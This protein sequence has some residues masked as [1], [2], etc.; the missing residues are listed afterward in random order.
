MKLGLAW[1]GAVLLLVSVMFLCARLNAQTTSATV[2]GQITDQSGKLVSGAVVVLTNINT[3][4][5]Y[6]TVTNGEGI[7]S[8]PTLQPGVYRAN[9]T[10]DGFKSIVKPDIE[11]HVQDQVSLNFA[12]EIGSVSET[13]TVEAGGLNINTTDASV[14][15]VIDRDFVANIPLNG[16]SLQSL[17]S[18]T[19]GVLVVASQ[20]VGISGEF[21]VNGQ[22]SEADYFTVDGVSAN[23]GASP[24]A[25]FSA[26]YGGALA[27]ET[28]LGTT[29]SVISLDA[30]QE[31]RATT[32]TYSAE[33]GRTPGGQFSFA[34]ASG[35]NDWHGSLFDYF[36]NEALDANNWFSNAAGIPKTPERQ[37]DFGGT[38]G[39][40]VQIPG[41][42]DGKDKTFFFF[43]YEGLRLQQPAG[44]T[45]DQYPDTALRQ[46]APSAL[47]PFLNAFPIPTGPEVLDANGNPTGLALFT[48][49]Y[50]NP[51][52]LDAISIR[53]DHN[54]SRSMKIFG[55]YSDSPSSSAAR[56]AGSN[57]ANSA[58][59]QIDVKGVTLGAT[60]A[61]SPRM[62]NDFRF[63]YT[64]N[65]EI[66]SA[67]LDNFGGA[68][69]FSLDHVPGL[70]VGSAAEFDVFQF[71]LQFGARPLSFL[72]KQLAA[73]Q[74][75]NLINAIT[76]SRGSHNFKFGI[77]YRRLST[78][79]HNRK[80]G[81]DA[82]FSSASNV[83]L[84]SSSAFVF[85]DALVPPE[86]LYTNFSA[87][88]QD[89]WKVNQRLSL[90]L[91]L[92]WDLALPP[93]NGNG[94]LP[95][96]LNEITDLSTAQLAPTGT[97]LWKTDYHSF[98]PRLGAAYVLRA[99]AGTET[100]VRGGF[101]IFYDL[102]NAPA[103][104]GF[105]GVGFGGYLSYGGV[106]VPLSSAQLVI[107]PASVAPPYDNEVYAFDP[108][109][110]LPY[111]MQ[112]NVAIEQALG[113]NQ[114][115]TLTY[116]GS[117]GR[118]L[119]FTTT[120]Y[121]PT[122][123]NFSSG[124]GLSLTTGAASSNYNALQVEFQ[125]KLSRGLQMLASYTWSHS[126]DDGSSNFGSFELLRASSDFDIR[127]NF[128]TALTYN[129]PGSYSNPVVSG[130]LKHWGL[131]TRISARS[132]LPVDLIG[133]YA[134]LGT[135]QLVELRPDLVTGVPIYVYGPQYPGGE[136]INFGAF[137][138]AAANTEGDVPRNLVRGFGSVQ[139][140]LALR[141]DFP[142]SER[143]HLQFRTE[144]FNLF[145]HPSFGN[146][147]NYLGD[148]P[149]NSTTHSGFG[150]AQSTLNNA[151]GGL[152]SLYQVGGPRSFQMSLK[153]TF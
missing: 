58:N 57:L 116:V 148:G 97:P 31:F 8:L 112:W 128:Q 107:P 139:A 95:Y 92:R 147:D 104:N 42:Y 62:D 56:R 34:S 14:S 126:I 4:V 129:I 127:H 153:L 152:N 84:N 102:G 12:L 15:T 149:Y 80:L 145:N 144:A 72:E 151:L 82:S 76:V 132:A 106:P 40:P 69:P 53:V 136:I 125:K 138:P 32:S 86:P 1:R 100:V 30:L 119:L 21:S 38:L 46:T 124:N 47:Q 37:N 77:D 113:R 114:A 66:Y 26:G 85:S 61:I 105:E 89:E 5:P 33:Y 79:L 9:I 13:V 18:L 51:S 143:V 117:A 96:T 94:V 45:T 63:N 118:D 109:L 16:R 41:V 150:G 49:A 103:S 25:P 24:V 93:G 88:A 68:Q 78:F 81:E 11:L 121:P 70:G 65:N 108:H 3:G 64:R 110:K 27:S 75:W 130:I 10:K 2:T 50:S 22:R 134:L 48:A 39:G 55:R 73:Q 141:R 59:T 90:S 122:N 111:T 54:V 74:Q 140:D 131:D 28:A 98:A 20:G 17:I 6:T 115:L 135:G 29:Q 142:I 67:T 60:N 123:P 36:R 99:S 7:Y 19:P 52:S 83:L 133:S 23:T 91:G 35:A 101:G 43:S 146:I 137:Q 120:L 44:A 71:Y 87:Y